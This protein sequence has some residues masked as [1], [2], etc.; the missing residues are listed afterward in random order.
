MALLL[1][2]SMRKG[3]SK[4]GGKKLSC[5]STRNEVCIYMYIYIYIHI[6]THTHREKERSNLILPTYTHTYIWYL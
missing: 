2:E 4:K 3:K 5:L 1:K 6:Y